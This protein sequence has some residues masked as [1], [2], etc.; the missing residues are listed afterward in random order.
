VFFLGRVFFAGF[1]FADFATCNVNLKLYRMVKAG[2]SIRFG[3]GLC[4]ERPRGDFL[5]ILFGGTGVLG[6]IL[7]KPGGKL[8]F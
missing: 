8:P 6:G 7:R 3:S 5:S 2:F 4:G 1:F